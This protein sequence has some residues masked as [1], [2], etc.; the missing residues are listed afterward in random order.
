MQGNVNRC[1]DSQFSGAISDQLSEVVKKW[2]QARSWAR[3]PRHLLDR[4]RA[5][6]HFFT[7]SQPSGRMILFEMILSISPTAVAGTGASHPG[8]RWNNHVRRK[9]APRPTAPHGAPRHLACAPCDTASCPGCTVARHPATISI[10][11]QHFWTC[12][13]STSRLRKIA[14]RKGLRQRAPAARGISVRPGGRRTVAR[15]AATIS[16]FPNRSDVL[17][18]CR[19]GS[20]R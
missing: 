4:P 19:L 6:P 15:P 16:I 9:I 14:S 7:R 11:R 5:S 8:T 10:F 17:P 3:N 20:A 12:R 1:N 2:G 13:S 18:A